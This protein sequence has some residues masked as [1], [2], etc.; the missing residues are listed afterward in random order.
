MKDSSAEILEFMAQA[1]SPVELPKPMELAG[2]SEADLLDLV[3]EIQAVGALNSL[4]LACLAAID[5][6]FVVRMMKGR[7]KFDA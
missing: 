3:A 6:E 5:S 2:Y 4:G 1:L 7:E